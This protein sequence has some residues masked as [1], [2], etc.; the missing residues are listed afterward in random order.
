MRL[1]KTQTSQEKALRTTHADC[2]VP[3]FTATSLL[4]GSDDFSL[5]KVNL[6]NPNN[7]HTQHPFSCLAGKCLYHMENRLGTTYFNLTVGSVK[8]KVAKAIDVAFHTFPM[9]LL[10]LRVHPQ[11]ILLFPGTSRILAR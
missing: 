8:I 4:M 7:V 6:K 2:T 5:L 9:L 3:H 11:Q 10:F 1:S